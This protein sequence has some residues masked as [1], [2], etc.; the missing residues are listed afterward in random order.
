[1]I[2]NIVMAIPMIVLAS[3]SAKY[4]NDYLSAGFGATSQIVLVFGSASV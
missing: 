4:T 3:F 2:S 1:M